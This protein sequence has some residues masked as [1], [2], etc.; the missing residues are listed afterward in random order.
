MDSFAHDRL[1]IRAN[2][3]AA[4]LLE[5]SWE[6]TSRER[7]PGKLLLPY[8]TAAMAWSSE[9]NVGVEMRFDKLEFFN[10]AT[11]MVIVKMIHLA[12]SKGIRMRLTYASDVE[13]QSLSF[14]PMRVF[15]KE[16]IFEISA[17]PSRSAVGGV[18]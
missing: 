13:W 7:E 10:S 18:S 3:A 14:R 2:G 4:N 17:V 15:E 9:R 1:T 11:V 6:G 12:R 5:L 16:G 8:L